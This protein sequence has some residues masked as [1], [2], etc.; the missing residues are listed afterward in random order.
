MDV[1]PV[2]QGLLGSFDSLA[3]TEG[4]SIKSVTRSERL[5]RAV[6]R[7]TG[8]GGGGPKRKEKKNHTNKKRSYF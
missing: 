5:G 3:E 6:T 2:L 8:G 1:P 7:T 4:L